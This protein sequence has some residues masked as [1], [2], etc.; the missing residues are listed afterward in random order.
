MTLVRG[1]KVKYHFTLKIFIPN[2]VCVFSQIKDVEQI[3]GTF[4]LPPGMLHGG[5]NMSERIAMAH[6]SPTRSSLKS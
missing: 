2:S 6:S 5:Q 4:I 3:D 1:Q